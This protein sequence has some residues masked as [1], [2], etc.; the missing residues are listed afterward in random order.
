MDTELKEIQIEKI[1]SHFD[2][3][4]VH[5]AMYATGWIWNSSDGVP[6]IAEL[7][8][9]AKRLLNEVKTNISTGGFEAIKDDNGDLSLSFEFESVHISEL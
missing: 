6:S 1:I 4:S 5:K 2:F 7:K 8:K 9:E 3:K